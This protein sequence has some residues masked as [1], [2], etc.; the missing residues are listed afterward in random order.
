MVVTGLECRGE[1]IQSVIIR[2]HLMRI[3]G[4]YLTS[5]NVERPYVYIWSY[6]N[7]SVEMRSLIIYIEQKRH[8]ITQ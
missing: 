5:K 7:D 1:S 3:K 6:M 8:P 4:V 2:G